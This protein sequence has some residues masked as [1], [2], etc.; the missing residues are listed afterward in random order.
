[1]M[2]SLC[3]DPIHINSQGKASRLLDNAWYVGQA[4]PSVKFISSASGSVAPP[5]QG[6]LADHAGDVTR[7]PASADVQLHGEDALRRT[8]T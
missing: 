2:R 8:S 1:M 6:R 3:T 7:S 5:E 4:E